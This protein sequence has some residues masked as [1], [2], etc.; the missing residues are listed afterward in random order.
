MSRLRLP[1]NGLPVKQSQLPPVRALTAARGRGPRCSPFCAATGLTP[2][3][4]ARAAVCARS[5]YGGPAHPR[6]GLSVPLAPCR[7]PFPDTQPTPVSVLAARGASPRSGPQFPGRGRPRG[8]ARGSGRAV[9]AAGRPP[10]PRPAPPQAGTRDAKGFS[11]TGLGR[12]GWS[13]SE[14]S[15]LPSVAVASEAGGDLRGRFRLVTAV[16]RSQA[17]PILSKVTADSPSRPPR[18]HTPGAA[19][20]PGW[21]P[22]DVPLAPPASGDP[23]PTPAPGFPGVSLCAPD[24]QRLPG[25]SLARSPPPSR[26]PGVCVLL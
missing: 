12:P 8:P 4:D 25:S 19:H 9:G 2:R 14:A 17:G 3:G 18:M 1:G 11:G 24:V 21:A 13:P 16:S 15:L 5:R 26:A 23:P 10:I 22:K 7:R 6:H 20:S